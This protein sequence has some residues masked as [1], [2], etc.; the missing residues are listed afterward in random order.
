MF[1]QPGNRRNTDFVKPVE[2]LVCHRY[3]SFMF[4]AV[5][6]RVQVSTIL[7]KTSKIRW[8]TR[9]NNSNLRQNELLNSSKLFR[10]GTIK[11]LKTLSQ[12]PDNFDKEF[13]I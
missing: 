2:L 9:S 11:K 3:F 5:T 12:I 7:A 1:H 10:N 13:L 4:S 8:T 6:Y